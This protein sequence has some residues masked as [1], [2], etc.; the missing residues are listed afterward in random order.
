MEIANDPLTGEEFFRTRINQRF[1]KPEN[2]IKYYNE[3]ANTLRWKLSFIEKPLRKNYT[4]INSLMK[5]QK[6]KDFHKEY[7][8]GS[9]FNFSVFS[10][11]TK[12]GEKKYPTIYEYLIIADENERIKIIRDDRF[13]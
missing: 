13:Y 10:H 11:F 3:K 12:H 7:L 1:A 5:N 4:I 8:R 9:G 2:R 6:E